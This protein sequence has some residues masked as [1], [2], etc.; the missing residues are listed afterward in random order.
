MPKRLLV[1]RF[2]IT[3]TY[4]SNQATETQ[5]HRDGARRGR[6]A[7]QAEATGGQPVNQRPS[8]RLVVVRS[9][10]A[11]LTRRCA[12]PASSVVSRVFSVSRC[13]CAQNTSRYL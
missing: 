5:R 10:I 7:P 8:R 13:L 11:R 6:P 2:V 3:T 4:R 9:P 1:Q 12:A